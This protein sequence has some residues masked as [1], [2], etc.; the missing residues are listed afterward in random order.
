MPRGTATPHR[1]AD[2]RIGRVVRLFVA[3]PGKK[4][5]I[6]PERAGN[7]LIHVFA[8]FDAAQNPRS[9]RLP[10]PTAR[11]CTPGIEPIERV[12]W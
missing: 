2:P 12:F 1:S 10:T 4:N 9:W 8:K 7:R 5:V 11:P 6:L 3:P